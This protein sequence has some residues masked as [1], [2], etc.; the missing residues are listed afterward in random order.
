[1]GRRPRRN[2]YPAFIA[3]AA[4][5]AIKGEKTLIEL[6]QE[7]DVHPN[8]IKQLRDQHLEAATCVFGEPAKSELE[9]S[10]VVKTLHAQ[11][12][13]LTLENDFLSLGALC[14]SDCVNGRMGTDQWDLVLGHDL[15]RRDDAG[16]RLLYYVPW[17]QSLFFKDSIKF[18]EFKTCLKNIES[19]HDAAL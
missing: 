7:L 12:G 19:A 4:V 11:I 3:K 9:M 14:L 15:Y 6:A 5:S 1:M 10:I 18:G 2:H 8:Q 16:A 13:E 17:P